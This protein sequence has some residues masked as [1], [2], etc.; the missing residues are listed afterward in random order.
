MSIILLEP[1]DTSQTC[2]GA[3]QLIAMKDT[4][5][6]HSQGK[7]TP[8]T[9]TVIKHHT[10]KENTQLLKTSVM[11]LRLGGQGKMNNICALKIKRVH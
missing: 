9:G 7:F 10:N 3:W 8:W 1:P 6:S 11:N 2:Q 4:K 5:I